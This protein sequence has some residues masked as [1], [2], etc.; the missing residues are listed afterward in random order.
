MTK[1]RMGV[2]LR[3]ENK[4]GKGASALNCS[5]ETAVAMRRR[6][7]ARGRFSSRT[8]LNRII[9]HLVELE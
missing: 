7:R 2:S 9:E 8:Q 4:S 6:T 5:C 1:Q 3:A